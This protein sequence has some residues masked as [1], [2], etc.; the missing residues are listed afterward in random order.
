MKDEFTCPNC[1]K[2]LEE[3]RRSGLLGC[4]QCYGVFR[5]EVLAAVKKVQGRTLHT[6]RA[7]APDAKKK[8]VLVIEQDMLYESLAQALREGRYAEADRMQERLKEISREL[9]PEEDVT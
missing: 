5:T 1:G 3:F 4:A 2:T 8:Y 9:H 6:G 7:P